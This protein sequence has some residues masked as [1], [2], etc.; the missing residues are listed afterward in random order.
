MADR[1]LA[2]GRSVE[3]GD[4]LPR[5]IVDRGDAPLADRNA[6]E[7]RHDSLRHRH[8]RHAVCGRAVVLVALGEDR[9]AAHDR[10]ARGAV[11][12]EVVVEARAFALESKRD[13]GLALEAPELQRAL[14]LANLARRIHLVTAA[15]LADQAACLD[16]RPGPADRVALGLAERKLVY[17]A[18][19]A[20]SKSSSTLAPMGSW[21]K[22]CQMPEPTWRLSVCSTPC[23]LSRAT[24][25]FSPVVLKAM[26]SIT[27]AR[28]FGSLPPEMCR[29]GRPPA[30]SQRPGNEKGGRSPSVNPR[31]PT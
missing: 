16:A 4:V 28:S 3:V 5:L 19:S 21:Q 13:V 1:R 12:R 26:W 8:R 2:V 23:S 24:V 14:P 29:I 25:A 17:G 9:V 10:E 6:D 11:A 20:G 15:E 31:I 22:I 7:H 18:A 27:P 30:Y